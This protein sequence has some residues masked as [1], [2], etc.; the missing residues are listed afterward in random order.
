MIRDA[1]QLQTFGEPKD[2]LKL[3]VGVA[4]IQYCGVCF[5]NSIGYFLSVL[6]INH[7]DIY[8]IFKQDRIFD[9][10]RKKRNPFFNPEYAIKR[11]WKDE[12]MDKYESNLRLLENVV[13]QFD[14]PASWLEASIQRLRIGA[15]VL[16]TAYGR[17]LLKEH[18]EIQ[19]LAD[20]VSHIYASFACLVRANRSW[21]LKLPETEQERMLAGCACDV[22]TKIVKELMEKAENGPIDQVDKHYLNIAKQLI[23]TKSYFPVHPLTRFF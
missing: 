1:V 3:Y 12:S 21:I 8:P 2:I 7:F 10:V 15:N 19:R 16:M 17:N 22:N 6:P 14:R 20:T 23:K 18:G 13:S 5:I 11:F 4:G 9:D